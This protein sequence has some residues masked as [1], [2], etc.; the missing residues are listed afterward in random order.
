MTLRASC[1]SY[2]IASS[3]RTGSYLL[4]EGLEA[5]GVAGR[6]TEVFSPEFQ[7]I[8]R[9]RWGLPGDVGFDS[10]F[11]CALR[12]G[13]TANGVYGLKI[14]WMHV[15]RLARQAGRPDAGDAIIEDLFPSARFVHIV[16]R[17]RRAQAIS[18][19]R[20]VETNEWWRI[21]GICNTQSNGASA[22]FDADAIFRLEAQLAWQEAQWRLYFEQRRMRPLVIEYEVLASDYRGQVARVLKY[23]GLDPS[24]SRRLSEPRLV[25]QADETTRR[26]RELLDELRGPGS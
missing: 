15:D 2:I 1:K 9:H 12:H 8:W 7:G 5:C 17:D 25:R 6:P 3:P 19:F 16:R 21:E 23:L 20:A 11:D 13:T 10:Y 24:V 14:H 4:C 22:T 26:W 18:Y